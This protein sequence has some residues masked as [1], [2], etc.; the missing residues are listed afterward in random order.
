MPA[1]DPIKVAAK[2]AELNALNQGTWIEGAGLHAVTQ[3]ESID[4]GVKFNPYV[5]FPLKIFVNLQTGE[6]KTYS[7]RAFSVD[8]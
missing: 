6:V 2:L 3:F 8:K 5:G 1:I 7:A 4:N